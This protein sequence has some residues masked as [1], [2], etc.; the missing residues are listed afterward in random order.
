MKISFVNFGIEASGSIVI[1]FSDK[2]GLFITEKSENDKN[3]SKLFQTNTKLSKDKIIQGKILDVI[4]PHSNDY[5]RIIFFKLE[6]IIN[7]NG[8]LLK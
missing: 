3:I 4:S 1:F 6:N 2:E 7:L 8:R 5:D